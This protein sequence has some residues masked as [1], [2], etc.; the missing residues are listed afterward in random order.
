MHLTSGSVVVWMLCRAWHIVGAQL[1][2]CREDLFCYGAYLT[3]LQFACLTVLWFF[4]L[5]FS[6]NSGRCLQ[7]IVHFRGLPCFLS[8][9]ICPFRL[10]PKKCPGCTLSTSPMRRRHLVAS[11]E[12]R[13]LWCLRMK[14]GPSVWLRFLGT[15]L[16]ETGDCRLL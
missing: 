3:G 10:V 6:L 8:L 2:F 13:P 4:F 7:C 12:I 15:Q 5:P 9:I 14:T 1:M 16:Q 11:K